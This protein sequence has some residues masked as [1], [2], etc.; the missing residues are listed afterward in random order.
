MP[1]HAPSRISSF[2]HR[3]R[4][5]GEGRDV[6]KG[7]GVAADVGVHVHGVCDL[8]IG[9]VKRDRGREDRVGEAIK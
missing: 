1:L 9:T 2:L 7:D 8:G 6:G 4:A 5:E 3:E